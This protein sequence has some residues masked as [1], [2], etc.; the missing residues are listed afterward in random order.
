MREGGRGDVEGVDGRLMTGHFTLTSE[1]Q[2]LALL[3]RL[4]GADGRGKRELG[5]DD[6]R[7]RAGER[8]GGMREGVVEKIN[9]NVLNSNFLNT[10]NY[11]NGA[12]IKADGHQRRG[13]APAE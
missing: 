4:R 7:G 6:R 3:R 8:G 9:F 11:E 10:K 5:K 13:G 12:W 1:S 2:Q